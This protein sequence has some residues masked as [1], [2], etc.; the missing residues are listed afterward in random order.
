MD[1]R[2]KV[3]GFNVSSDG[4]RIEVGAHFNGRDTEAGARYHSA[5]DASHKRLGTS[6]P[7][8]SVSIEAKKASY[9]QT[10]EEKAQG[11]V[12]VGATVTSFLDVEQARVLRDAL[13]RVLDR[14]DEDVK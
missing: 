8:I 7:F 14:A 2:F 13:T 3:F 5:L 9:E 6:E 12:P 10:A 1:F 11:Y 4:S